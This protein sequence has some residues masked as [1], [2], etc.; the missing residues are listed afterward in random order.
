[1]DADRHQQF[2]ERVVRNQHRV[3]RYIVSLVA[4]RADAEELF[5]QTC[6]TLWEHWDRYD[7]ALDFLPWA[8]G[9]AHNHVRN[10]R[11]RKEHRQVQLDADVVELLA[12]R[13]EAVLSRE[14]DGV[15][16]LRDC[17]ETLPDASR[18]VIQ[19]YYSGRTVR[20]IAALRD[21]TPNAIYKM[22]DRIRVALHECVAAR[23][24]GEVP[25]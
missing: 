4:N 5:Q 10:F 23:L 25:G 15:A 12:R 11:R 7:P 24:A 19:G 9:I 20:E 16:A 22:L 21:A 13:S 1:M 8:C 3:F 17:L 2:A 14:S 6:L 18:S